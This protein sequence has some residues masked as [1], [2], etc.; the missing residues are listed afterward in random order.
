MRHT[1]SRKP[2]FD[3]E[4]K[5]MISMLP[6]HRQA[7]MEAAIRAYQMSGTMPSKLDGAEMMAFLLIKKIVDR[8]AK[9]RASRIRKRTSEN[10]TLDIEFERQTTIPDVKIQETHQSKLRTDRRRAIIRH[11]NRL[12]AKSHHREGVSK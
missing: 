11:L 5:E 2:R 8:R 1:A 9:Q 12:N 6:E 10:H 7:S 4:W 3:R